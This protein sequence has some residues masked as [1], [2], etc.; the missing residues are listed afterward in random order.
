MLGSSDPTIMLLYIKLL[1]LC[2]GIIAVQM[3]CR[4]SYRADQDIKNWNDIGHTSQKF[5]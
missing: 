3:K 4:I 1:R 2:Y 5:H